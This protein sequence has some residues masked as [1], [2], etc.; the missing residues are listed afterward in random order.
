MPTDILQSPRWQ[1]QHLGLPMPD[2]PHAVSACLPLWQ[3]NIAYEEG[4]PQI[5]E[6]LRASYPRFCLHP[7]VRRLCEQLFPDGHG[8]PFAN[9]AAAD[10]AIRYVERYYGVA[11]QIIVPDQPIVGVAVS[12]DDFPLLKQYWQHAGEIVS[13]RAAEL[14]LVGQPVEMTQTIARST[15]R[16]RVAQRHDAEPEDVFLFASGM[17]AIAAAQRAVDRLFPQRPACQFGFPYV[18]TLKILERFPPSSCDFFAIGDAT[19]LTRLTD[20]SLDRNYSAV[21]CET[22]TNPLLVTPDLNRLHDLV[23]NRESAL[24][25]DDTLR[26]CSRPSVLPLTD[27]VVTSLTKYFSGYGNVLAGSLVL[28]RKSP[29]YEKFRTALTEDFTETLCDADVEVLERNSRDL[30][31]RVHTLT[32]NARELVRRLKAH[33]AVAAVF[34]PDDAH[35][36]ASGGLFSIVLRDAEQTTPEVFDALALNKGPNL[37]ANFTLC[38][39]FTILA[40]YNELDFAEE[41]GVSRWLLRFSVGVEPL[42]ELWT[43]IRST[44]DTAA[45]T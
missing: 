44:L 2:D 1:A 6:T 29:Q 39:P 9:A 8:L 31:A 13:S 3:H 12:A 10:R 16:D 22:P 20:T 34:Y 24:I 11:R 7:L 25:V 18:D 15:V 30:D 26:A 45:D 27:I 17:A 36:D 14:T 42:E 4:D 21:F 19:D 32:A 35:D 43:R 28:N 5:I 38:C 23:R 33:P 40:H 41:C 37:G